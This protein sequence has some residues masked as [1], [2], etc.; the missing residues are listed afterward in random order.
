MINVNTGLGCKVL[1]FLHVFSL[2]IINFDLM[3]HFLIS[4]VA[5]ARQVHSDRLLTHAW[6]H[7]N[8][9][10][11]THRSL[12]QRQE[13]V[14]RLGNQARMRRVLTHWRFCILYLILKIVS[15]TALYQIQPTKVLT[16]LSLLQSLDSITLQHMT[17]HTL[18]SMGN[19][20]TNHLFYRHAHADPITWT[21]FRCR[22]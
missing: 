13:Q 7:W 5:Q 4:V 20:P 1:C 21:L 9:R 14:D 11:F 12:A 19:I 3:Y 17:V 10:W 6:Q 18:H 22:L 2:V 8:Q 15:Y 16:V